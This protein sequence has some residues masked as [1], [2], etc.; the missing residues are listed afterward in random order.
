MAHGQANEPQSPFGGSVVEDIVARVNDQ[1]ITKS[2]YDRALDELDQEGRQRNETMQEI[3]T[4][5]TR[6]CCAT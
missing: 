3:S 5:R 4:T 1:I 6:I 2:D